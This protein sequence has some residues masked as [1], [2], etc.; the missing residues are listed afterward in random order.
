[1][2]YKTGLADWNQLIYHGNVTAPRSGQTFMSPVKLNIASSWEHTWLLS[3]N[4]ISAVLMSH[5][6]PTKLL[7]I[8][9]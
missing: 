6:K 2:I 3:F 7:V 1:M 4:N 9:Y 8:M 5:A